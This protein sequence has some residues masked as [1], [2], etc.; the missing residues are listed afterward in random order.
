MNLRFTVEIPDESEDGSRKEAGEP[1]AEE[2]EDFSDEARLRLERI[3][4][5]ADWKS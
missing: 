4:R 2:E 1:D 5:V 3:L